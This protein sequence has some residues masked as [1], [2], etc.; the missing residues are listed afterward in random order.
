MEFLDEVKQ[1]LRAF[2]DGRCS[3]KEVDQQLAPTWACNGRDSLLPTDEACWSDDQHLLLWLAT[4]VDDDM[5]E[6]DRR[7]RTVLRA[8][9][10][11]GKIGAE[12][13]LRLMQFILDQDRFCVI[14]EKVERGTIDRRNLTSAIWKAGYDK[15]IM[16]SLLSSPPE[17]LQAL[18]RSL[19]EDNYD[20]VLSALRI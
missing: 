4:L 14:L 18:R 2:A 5:E 9:T 15:S 7:R 10:Y 8:L 16:A 1:I 17:T 19:T 12:R 11:E 13:T 3:A 20:E 6:E